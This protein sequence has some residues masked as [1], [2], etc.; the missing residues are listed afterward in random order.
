MRRTE[1][2]NRNVIPSSKHAEVTDGKP[3]SSRDVVSRNIRRAR[4]PPLRPQASPLAEEL[5]PIAIPGGTI[6]RIPPD[7]EN[8]PS[9]ALGALSLRPPLGS[10]EP[11]S[12]SEADSRPGRGPLGGQTPG[13][14]GGDLMAPSSQRTRTDSQVAR[15]F[16]GDEFRG[17]HQITPRDIPRTVAVA[18]SNM[19]NA[20]LPP[21]EG[22]PWYELISNGRP[23][24]F[25]RP[26]HFRSGL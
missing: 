7:D 8:G 14:S 5:A 24:P 16:G 3:H 1:S 17:R 23:S 6:L 15:D 19:Q 2:E 20:R 13:R 9:P 12:D 21:L 22:W 26:P 10:F 4:R 25:R 11:S 18:D